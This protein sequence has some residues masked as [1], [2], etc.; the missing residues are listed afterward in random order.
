M[1]IVGRGPSI[2]CRPGWHPRSNLVRG[3]S[4]ADFRQAYLFSSAVERLVVVCASE[5][6]NSVEVFDDAL[7]TNSS[8]WNPR[9]VNIQVR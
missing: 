3:K 7:R 6:L 9:H 4:R 8:W 2:W 5:F 1:R